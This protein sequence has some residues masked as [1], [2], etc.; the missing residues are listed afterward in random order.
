M[1]VR[2]APTDPAAI[3]FGARVSQAT[4]TRVNVMR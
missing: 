2:V 3:D 4:Y 1:P